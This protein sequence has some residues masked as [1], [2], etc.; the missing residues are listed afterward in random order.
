MLKSEEDKI[1]LIKLVGY[2]DKKSDYQN[3]LITGISLLMTYVGFLLGILS[4]TGFQL[5]SS[6][7]IKWEGYPL[8]I[9]GIIFLFMGYLER[10]KASK[11]IEELV[12]MHSR[13]TTQN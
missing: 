7:L 13:A 2:L 9:T 3:W 1:F 4:S 10:K 11:Y 12:K 5:N 8:L 6:I